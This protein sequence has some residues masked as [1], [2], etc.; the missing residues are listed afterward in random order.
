MWPF[1][2]AQ[3]S[4]G[5]PVG[6]TW[7]VKHTCLQYVVQVADGF[8]FLGLLFLTVEFQCS[9]I[10]FHH[11]VLP[12]CVTHSR[13]STG[14]CWLSKSQKSKFFFSFYKW[15]LGDYGFTFFTYGQGRLTINLLRELLRVSKI[16]LSWTKIIALLE[17]PRTPKE[18]S[19][20]ESGCQPLLSN[21]AKLLLCTCPWKELEIPNT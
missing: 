10:G 20:L 17:L 18:W 16:W 7:A 6:W 13:F 9:P 21:L 11:M 5:E 8:A 2:E 14:M 15:K 4:P 1:R 3:C 19:T 12:Q